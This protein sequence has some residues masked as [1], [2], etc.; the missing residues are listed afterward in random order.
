MTLDYE[1]RG[2]KLLTESDLDE[3]V[4]RCLAAEQARDAALQ[5]RAAL[6]TAL[7]E[8]KDSLHWAD[9]NLG[10]LV[11]D[12]ALVRGTGIE[13]VGFEAGRRALRKVIHDLATLLRE[14]GQ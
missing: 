2:V 3:F 8:A 10:A 5:A 14:T 12:S 11:T 9:R 13:L 6:Q 4:D 7:T 1:R